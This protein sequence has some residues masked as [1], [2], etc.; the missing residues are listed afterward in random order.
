[1]RLVQTL[2]DL[3]Q[4]HIVLKIDTDVK[5]V[6]DAA[7][8]LDSLLYDHRLT[9]TAKSQHCGQMCGQMVVNSSSRSFVRDGSE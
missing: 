4:H 9:A 2:I 7:V 8:V 5:H 1:M 6:N 3:Q